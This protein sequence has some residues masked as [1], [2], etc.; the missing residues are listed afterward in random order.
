MNSIA[1]ITENFIN[2][3]PN[4]KQNLRD[5]IINYSK[6]SRIIAK[7]RDIDNFDAILV[8]IRRYYLKIK[9]Q[10]NNKLIIEIIKESRLLIRD[11]IIVVIINIDVPFEKLLSFQKSLVE[12]IHIT[13]GASAYTIIATEDIEKRIIESFRKDILKSSKGLVE[14]IMKSPIRLENVPGVM[15]YIYSLFSENEINILETIS[16]WTDTLFVIEKK[17]MGKT[18]E[19]LSVNSF[20]RD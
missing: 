19:I 6:L 9:K 2:T 13:R 14:I 3:H 7:E 10:S 15:G 11:K 1:K 17:D 5:G 16:C 12:P 20:D 4:I 18:V 8:S